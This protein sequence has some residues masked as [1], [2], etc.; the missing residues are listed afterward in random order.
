[1]WEEVARQVQE[2]GGK[3]HLDTAVRKIYTQGERVTGVEVYEGETGTYQRVEGDYVFSTMPVKELIRGLETDVPPEVRR[4]S[5]GLIYRDF[6]TVGL[7]VE[8]L[9]VKDKE[10]RE[11]LIQDNWI[12]VQEPDVLVG[13]IQIFNNWSPYLIQDSSKVWLGLEYFCY[14]GDDLWVKSSAEMGRKVMEELAL[15][16][17]QR[18]C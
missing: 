4:V 6:I 16:L 10:K 5:E 15:L 14:E 8:E 1:M 18:M 12:Y 3:L 11:G 2:R 9:I 13:R 17:N 7:L